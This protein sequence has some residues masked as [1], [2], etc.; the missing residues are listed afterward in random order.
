MIVAGAGNELIL[1][2][3]GIAPVRFSAVALA[4]M[5]AAP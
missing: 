4:L 1:N 3:S 5:G 2:V